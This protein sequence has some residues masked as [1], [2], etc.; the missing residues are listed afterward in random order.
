MSM[1]NTE[2]PEEPAESAPDA[3]LAMADMALSNEQ[4]ALTRAV[5]D[6]AERT[7]PAPLRRWL[8]RALDA[9][10]VPKRQPVEAW[11]PALAALAKARRRRL[12]YW[13]DD[14]DERL[15]GL[16]RAALRFSRPDGS[17][18]FDPQRGDPERL[19][20]L[21]FWA[22]RLDDPGLATVVR[23][24][25]DP[26]ATVRR[27]LA[28]PPLPSF[29]CADRPLAVLRAD[30][31]PKGDTLTIDGR[32][33]GG[34]DRLELVG[35]GSHLLGPTW[36][37]GPDSRPARALQWTTGPLADLAE[38][39]FRTS[40]GRVIRTAVLL[41][42]ENLALLT[43]QHQAVS[44]EPMMR[45]ALADG[46]EVTPNE[47]DR[48]LTL[49]AGRVKARLIPLALPGPGTS[50]DRGAL[51]VEEQ[52]VVLRQPAEGARS[53]LPLLISWRAER[54]RKALRLRKLTVTERSKPC[55]PDIAVA[56]LVGW[57]LGDG[58]VIYR[59]LGRPG[60]RTFL[61]HQTSARFLVGQFTKSGEVE[62][63]V[64]LE[65]NA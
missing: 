33:L 44:P 27:G 6:W 32:K 36:T 4:D 43:D 56:F 64:K 50:A 3:P 40:T 26:G 57:G 25:S 29:A 1:T 61:G 46:V 41:K 15:E 48:T 53:W 58:L 11:W 16:A 60:L 28:P 17:S 30:W 18:A 62:P 14:L 5:A 49:S 51:T 35:Q 34:S 8:D 38:W 42:G 21:K 45:L 39:T 22:R 24:W 55:P 19:D 31:S 52:D 13:P 47:E 10:G 2:Q 59:S 20:L 37:P 12:K 65:D 63:L 23:W 7:D 9:D 54:N